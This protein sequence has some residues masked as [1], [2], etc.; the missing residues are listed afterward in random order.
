MKWST[1]RSLIA[2]LSSCSPHSLFPH[3][4][5]AALMHAE[6]MQ[7]FYDLKNCPEF[8]SLSVL[9]NV[10]ARVPLNDAVKCLGLAQLSLRVSPIIFRLQKAVEGLKQ[11]QQRCQRA[12]WVTRNSAAFLLITSI[13]LTTERIT[14]S[15]LSKTTVVQ[16][17]SCSRGKKEEE[18]EEEDEE[19]EE[20]EDDDDDDTVFET[21]VETTSCL[22]LDN[23]PPPCQCCR[24]L[25]VENLRSRDDVNSDAASRKE[26]LRTGGKKK[27]KKTVSPL[28]YA[29]SLT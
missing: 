5:L 2:L 3:L 26:R 22:F 25:L 20:E 24:F 19:E 15:C 14:A 17:E 27:K 21:L 9:R 23:G 29:L 18:D 8:S 28:A 16:S 11:Y 4:A 6:G 7:E 1:E 10:E 13:P 12:E